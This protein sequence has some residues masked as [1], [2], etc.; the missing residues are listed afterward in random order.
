MRTLMIF[1]HP[2]DEVVFGWPVTQCAAPGDVTL[3]TICHNAGKYGSGPIDALREVCHHNKIILLEQTKRIECNFYRTPPRYEMPDLPHV[4]R[5]INAVICAAITQVKPDVI[6]THNPMGEY[7]HGDHRMLFNVVAMHARPMLL[8][9]ICISNP[10]HLS[11]P[12]IPPVYRKVFPEREGQEHRLN[13]HWYHEM[14]SIYK[15]HHSWSWS[16]HK[17]V[18]SCKLYRV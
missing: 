4:I 1:A 8:T 9:D 10:C 16:G 15:R 6:F 13:M 2:D 18:P 17:P 12:V 5:H 7:G 11:S 14:E 3:L